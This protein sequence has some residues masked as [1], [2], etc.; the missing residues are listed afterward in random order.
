VPYDEIGIRVVIEVKF[1]I[2]VGIQFGCGEE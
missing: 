2:V 1:E